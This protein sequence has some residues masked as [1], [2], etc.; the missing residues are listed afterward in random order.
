M[1]EKPI[2]SRFNSYMEP[3]LT[4]YLAEFCRNRNTQHALLRMIKSLW[5]L[6]NKSQKVDAIIMNLSKE[7]DAVNYALLKMIESLRTLLNKGQNVG[8]IVMDLS[9]VFDTL[10]HKLLLKKLQAYGFDK[11]F[12]FI[13]SYFTNRK[14]RTKI[15]D[16]FSKY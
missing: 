3:K 4:K 9:Q 2:Y 10:N 14:Q 13:E 8:A 5:A 11:K 16:S 7:F 1:F 12:F 15:G 6:L